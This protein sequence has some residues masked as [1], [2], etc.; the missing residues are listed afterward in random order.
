MQTDRGGAA[1]TVGSKAFGYAN[2]A[3][4]SWTP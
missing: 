2:D 1:W 3:V 4:E